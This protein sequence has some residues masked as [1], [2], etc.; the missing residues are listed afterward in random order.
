MMPAATVRESISYVADAARV[1][2][3]TAHMAGDTLKLSPTQ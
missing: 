1:T 2:Q 3:S